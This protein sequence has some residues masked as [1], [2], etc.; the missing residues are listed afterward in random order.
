MSI[1]RWRIPHTPKAR[2]ESEPE[3]GHQK[4]AFPLKIISIFGW[5][6]M[7]FLDDII[8]AVSSAQLTWPNLFLALAFFGTGLLGLM[9]LLFDSAIKEGVKARFERELAVHENTLDLQKQQALK[10]FGLFAEKRHELNIA[11][12]TSLRTAYRSVNK[13]KRAAYVMFDTTMLDAPDFDQFPHVNGNSIAGK[14]ISRP[15]TCDSARSC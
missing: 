13:A 9:R 3:A 14:K 10:D 5:S 6:P 11:V 2:N 12:Y 15:A 8:N 1:R 7:Q 4:R